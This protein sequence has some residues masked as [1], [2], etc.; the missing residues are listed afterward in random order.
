[1]AQRNE[2]GGALRS[3]DAGDASYLKYIALLAAF[4]NQSQRMAPHSDLPTGDSPPPSDLLAADIDHA[5]G[6]V[7][8]HVGESIAQGA[9]TTGSALAPAFGFHSRGKFST[10]ASS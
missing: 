8:V 6:A 10:A 1:M 2:I 7:L 3:L 9:F 4:A 5:R